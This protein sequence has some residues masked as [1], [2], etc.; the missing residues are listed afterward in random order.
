MPRRVDHDQRRREIVEATLR[1]VHRVGLAGATTRAIADEAGCT[2][3]VLAHF[4]GNKDAILV[5]AQGAV[6]ERMVQRGFRIGG[7]LRGLA[8]LRQALEAALPLDEERAVDAAANAAFAAAALTH[9][10]LAEARRRS[11]QDIRR[12]LYGCLTEARELGELRDGVDDGAVVH[13]F[14]VIAEGAALSEVL[15]RGQP[16]ASPWSR[17]L[18]SAFVERLQC[19]R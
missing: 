7:D 9:A 6:Y 14:F 1:V 17:D 8:A 15:D 3:S 16:G 10:D 4:F 13:E 2:L 5:A 12:V 19:G 18:A 11:R